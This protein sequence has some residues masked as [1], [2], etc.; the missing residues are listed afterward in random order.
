MRILWEIDVVLPMQPAVASMHMTWHMACH[1]TWHM[2]WHMATV[3]S[4]RA[5]KSTKHLQNQGLRIK[6]VE[7]IPSN[8]MKY[9]KLQ[10]GEIPL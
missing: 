9:T 2:T 4:S 3:R 8:C 10:N 7:S 6:V 1:M 5:K